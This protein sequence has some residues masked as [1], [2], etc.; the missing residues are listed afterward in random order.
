LSEFGTSLIVR[1][2]IRTREKKG[3]A[4]IVW[5]WMGRSCVLGVV[6]TAG[7]TV[8]S[9]MGSGE[10]VMAFRADGAMPDVEAIQAENDRLIAKMH[11]AENKGKNMQDLS[12]ELQAEIAQMPWQV[13]IGGF[14]VI[15]AMYWFFIRRDVK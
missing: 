11:E 1:I 10:T 3:G 12:N 14:G 2:K 13:G 5:K 7:L 9:T 4:M 8:A 6:L 15:F